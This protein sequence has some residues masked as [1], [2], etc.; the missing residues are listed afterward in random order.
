M[1][2]LAKPRSPSAAEPVA[3]DFT[4]A[5]WEVVPFGPDSPLTDDLLERIGA[6]FPGRKVERTARGELAV[7]PPNAHGG[8]P[9]Y[10]AE[11]TIQMGIW[12][13]TDGFGII[14]AATKGYE[15]E[16][17]GDVHAPDVSWMSPERAAAAPKPSRDQGMFVGVPE[18][19]IEIMS[20]SDS[21]P[22]HIRRCRAWIERDVQVMWMIDPF[23]RTLRVFRAEDPSGAEPEF[24][25]AVGKIAVG[26]LMPGFELDFDEVW[27]V[28]E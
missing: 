21:T 15:D 14:A 3:A 26:P 28:W 24:L 27:S 1:T 5:N 10:E 9:E 11:I 12:K 17:V 20:K 22:D 18:F 13:K 16:E 8:S 25:D 7:S 4:P 19:A 2:T 23:N 6:L